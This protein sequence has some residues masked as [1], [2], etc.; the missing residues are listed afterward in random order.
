MHPA[1]CS[2]KE[3]MIFTTIYHPNTDV[4]HMNIVTVY[5]CEDPQASR[6]IR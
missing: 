6:Y 2:G 1:L 5:K 3:L 4:H